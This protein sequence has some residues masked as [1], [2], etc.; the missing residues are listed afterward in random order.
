[1]SH[2][3]EVD[4]YKG[5]YQLGDHYPL[6]VLCVNGAHTP[7]APTSA[8]T[9]DIFDT[10]DNKVVTARAIP[11]KDENETGWFGE[12]LFL[13]SSFSAGQWCARY[14]YAISGTSYAKLD[15]FEII[16]GGDSAGAYTSLEYYDRPHGKFLMGGR[17][18]GTLEANRN[19]YL[20]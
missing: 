10:S 6:S 15:F 7:A 4:T 1:M 20:A 13:D 8:P 16:A 19:P 2:H 18:D 5:R 17:E 12:G 11:P 9:V 3:I 14:S